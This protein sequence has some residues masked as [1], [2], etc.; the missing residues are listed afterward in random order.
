MVRII[1]DHAMKTCDRPLRKHLAIISREIVSQY[2][3][4]FQDSF[5]GTVVGTG[6]DSL[7]NQLV[8]RTENCIRSSRNCGTFRA[9]GLHRD[10]SRYGCTSRQSDD[11]D[12]EVMTEKKESLKSLFVSKEGQRDI[13]VEE[14][15]LTYPLQRKMVNSSMTTR[16]L[17]KEWPYLFES[18][19]L[20]VHFKELVG[21]DVAQ[22]LPTA[23]REKGNNVIKFAKQDSEITDTV[24]EIFEALEK[25]P[26]SE[27]QNEAVAVTLLL[28]HFLK[29]PQDAVILAREEFSTVRDIENSLLPVTPRIIA[30]G[31]SPWA[32]SFMITVDHTV[33]VDHVPHFITA[34]GVWFSLHYVLNLVYAEESQ[35]FAEFLQRTFLGINPDRGSRAQKRQ[36]TPV[37]KKVLRL[38]DKLSTFEWNV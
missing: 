27:P 4:S 16:E 18:D 15:K 21:V 24:I 5:E 1:I 13:V 37:N 10:S 29:E 30:L 26:G 6:Y 9:G 19:G 7:L 31:D 25:A 23:F 32:D 8:F 20:F 14:M 38:V 2:P 17:L 11:I 22:V 36:K 35:A 28:L 34:V 3:S 33:V 12:E